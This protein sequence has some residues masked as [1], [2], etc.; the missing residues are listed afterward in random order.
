MVKFLSSQNSDIFFNCLSEQNSALLSSVTGFLP[1]S[2]VKDGIFAVQYVENSPVSA[3]SSG[4]R[5]SLFFTTDKSDIDELSLA[6]QSEIH[7]PN[8]LPFNKTGEYYLLK[9]V[10]KSIIPK[11]NVYHNVSPPDYDSYKFV[12]SQNG[13]EDTENLYYLFKKGLLLPFVQAQNEKKIGGGFI[14]NSENYSVI[15]HVFVKEEYR[16]HGHGKAIVKNLLKLSENRNVYLT[17][18]ENNL[19]FYGK[20]GFEPVLTVNKYNT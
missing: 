3:F 18:E 2:F 13:G 6:L 7:S 11:N 12:L 20:I 10:M 17:S 8:L 19:A 16:G 1:S 4:G 15:S 5:F 9:S 14:S